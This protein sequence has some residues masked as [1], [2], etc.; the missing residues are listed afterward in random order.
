[1]CMYNDVQ[2][3]TIR[4]Q[5]LKGTRIWHPNDAMNEKCPPKNSN[6]KRTATLKF[7]TNFSVF[8]VKL[9]HV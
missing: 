9:S 3:I 6:S 5:S 1:M 4:L 7:V 2:I 8:S